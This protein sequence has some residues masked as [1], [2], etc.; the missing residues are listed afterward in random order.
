MNKSNP[1]NFYVS[2]LFPITAESELNKFSTEDLDLIYI[3]NVLHLLSTVNQKY[4]EITYSQE[5]FSQMNSSEKLELF[6][7]VVSLHKRL[8][9]FILKNKDLNV[10]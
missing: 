7:Q 10:S 9:H 4:Q 8:S 1:L 2:S 3:S 5:L 6:N